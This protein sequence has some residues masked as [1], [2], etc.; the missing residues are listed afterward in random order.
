M[1][2]V[3]KVPDIVAVVVVQLNLV[4][5]MLARNYSKIPGEFLGQD[6]LRTEIFPAFALLTVPV[7]QCIAVN[8]ELN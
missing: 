8:P 1:F 6:A 3:K 7:Q 2:Q 5:P 4:Q